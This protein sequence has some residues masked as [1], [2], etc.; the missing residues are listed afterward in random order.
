MTTE[1]DE[2]GRPPVLVLEEDAI[3]SKWKAVLNISAS[4]GRVG[5]GKVDERFR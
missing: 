2:E 1:M 3:A 4:V 5:Q